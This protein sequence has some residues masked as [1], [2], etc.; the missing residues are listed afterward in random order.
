MEHVSD[1]TV[2]LGLDVNLYDD[3]N[4][5]PRWG[6]HCQT[7]DSSQFEIGPEFLDASDAVTWWRER[8]AKRIYIRLDFGEYLWAGE[9]SPSE[10]GSRFS[11]FDP[12]DPRGRPE[13]ATNTLDERRRTLSE[14]VSAKRVAAGLDEG[15][16]LTRRRETIHL[17]IEELADRAGQ[18]TEWLLDVESGKS[19]YDVTFSEWVNLVWATRPGWPDEMRTSGT[20]SVGWVAQRG[21]FLR[22]A[23]VFVNKMLGLY[24]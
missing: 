7:G 24:D 20:G 23:E 15:R 3:E 21:Q 12:A 14:V 11:V 10:D 16:R 5:P 13:G 19:T 8:G 22:E 1:G 9:G 2:Y 17:S 6:G 4:T 18:S